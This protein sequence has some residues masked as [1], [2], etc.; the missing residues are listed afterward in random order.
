MKI[1]GS[2]KRV[3]STDVQRSS[4][5]DST[6]V[7]PSRERICHVLLCRTTGSLRTPF[8]TEFIF[9]AVE[10]QPGVTTLTTVVCRDL[11]K[12]DIR[13]LITTGIAS[14]DGKT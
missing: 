3:L 14:S 11:G 7:R 1:S 6:A 8:A 2:D 10:L 12:N 5:H 13:V 9:T 4:S